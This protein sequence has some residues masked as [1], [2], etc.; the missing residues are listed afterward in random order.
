VFSLVN[1]AVS[2]ALPA[3]AAGAVAAG[4][5]AL[6]IEISC[7]HAAQQQARRTPLLWSNDGTDRQTET[8]RLTPGR[9]IDPAPHIQGGSKK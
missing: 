5:P 1:S 6:S 2:I 7:W 4:R 8:D 3:F 9:Y